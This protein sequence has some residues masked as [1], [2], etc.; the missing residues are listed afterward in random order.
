MSESP[1]QKWFSKPPP[2]PVESTVTFTSGCSCM[3]SSAKVSETGNTVELPVTTTSPESEPDPLSVVVFSEP[4]SPP[5]PVLFWLFDEQPASASAPT[6]PV[7]VRNFRL[8]A[9]G[10]WG[11]CAIN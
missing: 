4:P 9:F 7:A 1:G 5:S 10:R 11:F 6:A 2:L 3:N 8:D